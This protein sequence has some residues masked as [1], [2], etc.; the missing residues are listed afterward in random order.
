LFKEKKY[1]A[2]KPGPPHL[3]RCTRRSVQTP[4]LKPFPCRQALHA[5]RLRKLLP[6]TFTVAQTK[7]DKTLELGGRRCRAARLSRHRA[8]L[9]YAKEGIT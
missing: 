5:W 9:V 1:L 4:N 8:A 6:G 2:V 3:N 7:S